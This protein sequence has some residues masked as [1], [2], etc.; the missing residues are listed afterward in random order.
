MMTCK[1]FV[2]S[3]CFFSALAL[4][5]VQPAESSSATPDQV[6][7]ADVQVRMSDHGT[8]VLLLAEGKAI[9]IFVD[10]TVAL[11]IQG[12]L[13]G[14]K[15]PRPMTHDLMHSI[16]DAYGGKVLR[17]VIT[18]KGGTYYGTLTVAVKDQVKTFDSR[19]SDSIA[20]AIHFKA[21]IIVGRDLLDSAGRAIEK[22]KTETL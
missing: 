9:P 22:S 6:T 19:S 1:R 18:L 13:E 10:L 11:S 21:P 3:I 7:I 20:L 8:V 12:A 5:I 2:L 16:L 17:T 15:L 4:L 14:E